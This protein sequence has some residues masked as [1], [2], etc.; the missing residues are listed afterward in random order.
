MSAPIAGV[1]T[2]LPLPLWRGGGTMHDASAPG[3]DLTSYR[4]LGVVLAS[5]V[6]EDALTYLEQV[7]G[8]AW[9]ANMTGV[10]RIGEGRVSVHG[11]VVVF[12]ADVSLRRRRT[13]DR[14]EATKTLTEQIRQY[15]SEGSLLRR[16]GSRLVDRPKDIYLP[17]VVGFMIG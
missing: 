9:P 16:D 5:D 2:T 11:T 17:E 8:Y 6:D 7:I 14:E 4:L 3:A 15:Y 10:P 1:P 12:D 13:R